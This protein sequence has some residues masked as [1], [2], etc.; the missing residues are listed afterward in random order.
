MSADWSFADSDT[1]YLTHSLHPYAAKFVPQL[2]RL[3]IETLSTQGDVVLDPFCG[4]GTTLAEAMLL[5]RRAIGVD[6]N[7]LAK[8][9][10]RQN[11]LCSTIVIGSP[12]KRK[13]ARRHWLQGLG[14]L[15]REYLSSW[16][17]YRVS[18]SCF[19]TET[20]I[21]DNTASESHLAWI[22]VAPSQNERISAIS[23]TT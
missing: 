2:A 16:R 17:T 8:S 15:D 20:I 11:A 9:Y 14:G 19:E 22:V 5:G 12:S 7:P 4:S 10:R 23:S 6:A 3:L 13:R 18:E 1:G 21:D